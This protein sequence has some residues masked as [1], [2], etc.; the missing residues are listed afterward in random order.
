MDQRNQSSLTLTAGNFGQEVLDCKQ[1]VLVD[2]LAPWC[3]PCQVMAPVINDLAE[4][5]QSL[6]KVAKLN[7]DEHQELA[8]RLA[9]LV[10]P[11]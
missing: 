3:A 6:A 4:E 2:F 9:A 1:P 5:F 10:Q 8:Q 7:V 11:V